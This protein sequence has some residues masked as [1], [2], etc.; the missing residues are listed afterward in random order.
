MKFSLI[1]AVTAL[2]TLA[3][4]M[5]ILDLDPAPAPLTLGRTFR[6]A[7]AIPIQEEF[8][9]TAYPP[10]R[11]GRVS[12]TNGSKNIKTLL[13]FSLPALSGKSCTISFSD[14]AEVDKKGSRKMQLF[15]TGGYPAQGNT[16]NKKP[17]TDQHKGTFLT[18]EDGTGA[19]TVLENFGLKFPCPEFATSYGFEVQPVGDNDYVLWDITKGGFVITAD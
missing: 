15:T 16:W 18:S 17:F 12:R 13:G 1:T 2:S 6:P 10:T 4:G 3:S 5:V 19:A 8:P 7:I 11:W 14:A 9:D